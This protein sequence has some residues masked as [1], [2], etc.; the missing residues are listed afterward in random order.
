MILNEAWEIA[1]RSLMLLQMAQIHLHRVMLFQ[2]K[3]ELRKAR[4]IVEHCGYWRRKEE[5]EDAE[6]AAKNWA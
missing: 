5:L 1:E 2:D 6:Q 3:E 4:A